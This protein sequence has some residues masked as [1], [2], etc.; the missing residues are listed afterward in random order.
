MKEAR[1]RDEFCDGEEVS[2]ARGAA[3]IRGGDRAAV[4]GRD[5]SG[6][7]RGGQTGAAIPNILRSEWHGDAVLDA[8]GNGRGAGA[9]AGAGAAGAVPR[10]AHRAFRNQG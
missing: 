2:E 3:R 5:G 7:A 6:A 10:T 8:E 1:R 4:S 9:F